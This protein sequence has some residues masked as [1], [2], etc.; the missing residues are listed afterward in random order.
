[1][2]RVSSKGAVLAVGALPG[3]V[4]LMSNPTDLITF[5]PTL[6]PTALTTLRNAVTAIFP[7]PPA[8]S[9]VL[10][11]SRSTDGQPAGVGAGRTRVGSFVEEGSR[12]LQP[13]GAKHAT[14]VP[15]AE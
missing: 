4:G 9:A 3:Y 8:D 1:M 5:V 2:L 7:W 6:V 12:V 11:Y 13:G 14:S 10:P 15:D